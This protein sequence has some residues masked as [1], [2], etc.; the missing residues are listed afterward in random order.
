MR[1]YSIQPSELY[2]LSTDEVSSLIKCIE[3]ITAKEMLEDL[4]IADYPTLKADTRRKI[5]NDL[6]KKANPSILKPEARAITT[7]DLASIL[8]QG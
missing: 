3:I 7:K 6:K 8:N 2:C 5:F 4:V 1:F